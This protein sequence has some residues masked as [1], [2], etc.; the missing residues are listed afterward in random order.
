MARQG[1]F[2]FT[3]MLTTCTVKSTVVF[4]SLF[5]SVTIA[6]LLLGIGYLHRTAM[7]EPNTPII[8]AAGV[9][10]L[11]AAFLAWWVMFAGIADSSNSFFLVPVFHFPWSEKGKASRSKED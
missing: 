10:Q 4:F 9:L 2:I 3:F 8:K 7:N 6:F 1:W 5:F 11:I